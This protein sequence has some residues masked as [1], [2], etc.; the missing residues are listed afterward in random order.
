MGSHILILSFR[1]KNIKAGRSEA[2]ECAGRTTPP[3]FPLGLKKQPTM[4]IMVPLK[5]VIKT[6]HG[7]GLRVIST[8]MAIGPHGRDPC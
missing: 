1:R 3:N 4:H 7:G 8:D 6:R 5:S 2:E